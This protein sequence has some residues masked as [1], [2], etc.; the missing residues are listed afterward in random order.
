MSDNTVKA[1]REVARLIRPDVLAM[2]PYT[3]ILPFEVL[4]EQLG[5]PPEEIV[6]LDANENPYGP[7]QKALQALAS[8]ESVAHIYPDPE[9]RHLRE[10]LADYT[11]VPV[12]HILAGAGADELIDLTAR[13]FLD[14]GD[15][16]VNC[17]PTFGMYPFDAALSG[18]RVVNVPRRADFS[19]DV[20]GI[21]RAA[22]GSD[23]KLLFL[24][25]PN[26]PDGGLLE[27]AVLD[28]LLRLPL[29]VVVDEAYIEFSGAESFAGRVPAEPNL[30][31]LRTFSK[32]AGLAGLRIGYGLFPLTLIEQL[33]KIKQPYNVSAAAD[34][35]A[36]AALDDLPHLQQDIA[37][38]RAERDRL[39]AA[40]SEFPQLSPYPSRANFVLVRV[41]RMDAGALK[42]RLAEDYGI[43]VR[44][45]NKPG[46]ADH[47]RI[48]AGR[49]DQT[50]ALLGALRAIFEEDT[51]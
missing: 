48:S 13:L 35:A 51:P 49:P 23:A 46:L 33:W 29:A 5:R 37:R 40:L 32:W 6:K 17:P 14:R 45:F 41:A 18:G 11:G 16:V 34:H 15:A 9:A 38:I 43:L 26:N 30:I 24:T 3:P 19:L 4:S 36:R 20:E 42:R 47:I 12:E 39:Y 1:A 31:V 7:S 27:E 50:D 21:E 44:H 2:A 22:L 10:K 25:T 28:R 8:L